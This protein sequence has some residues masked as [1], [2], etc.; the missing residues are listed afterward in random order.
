MTVSEMNIVHMVN[1]VTHIVCTTAVEDQIGESY[2]QDYVLGNHRAKF[3]TDG[4]SKR[5]EFLDVQMEVLAQEH[6]GRFLALHIH[7][8]PE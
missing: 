1:I 7:A 4:A 5:M 3:K 8:L 6:Q 2:H